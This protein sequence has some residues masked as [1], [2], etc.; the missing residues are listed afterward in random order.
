[1]PCGGLAA[2]AAALVLRL[3]A[4][5]TPAP[6]NSSTHNAACC[7]PDPPPL[8]APA[9]CEAPAALAVLVDLV[10]GRQQAQQVWLLAVALQERP[11]PAP[12][13]GALANVV[14]RLTEVGVSR[15]VAAHALAGCNHALRVVRRSG[16]GGAAGPPPALALTRAPLLLS[17]CIHPANTLPHD[18]VHGAGGWLCDARAAAG[19]GCLSSQPSVFY[20]STL[21]SCST[22]QR[23]AN[24]WY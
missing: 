21:S 18:S 17:A 23:R 3:P 5:L 11:L 8:P 6:T 20:P 19:A 12:L 15:V 24:L 2:A 7:L 22:R 1:M 4:A 13:A 14:V 9:S 10:S 16:V